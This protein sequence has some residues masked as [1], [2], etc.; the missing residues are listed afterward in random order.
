MTMAARLQ[1]ARAAFNVVNAEM[2]ADLTWEQI[3]D[4][5]GNIRED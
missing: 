2:F 4:L 3:A 1:P 5:R